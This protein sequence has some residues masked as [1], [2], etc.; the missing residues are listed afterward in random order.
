MSGSNTFVRSFQLIDLPL[1][2]R[3]KTRGISLDSE[4]YLARGLHTVE[5]AALS[6][7]PLADLGKP[8]LVAQVDQAQIIGQYRH[9]AGAPD[10][11][12]MFITPTLTPRSDKALETAWLY[13]LDALAKA[14]GSHGAQTLRAEVDENSRVFEVLRQ[15]GY[16][17]YAR[18][19]I[20]RRNPAT[21]PRT[22]PAVHLRQAAQADLPALRWHYGHRVPR[23]AQQADPALVAGGLLYQ[24][25][26]T[27][28]GY[29]L[30]S[31]GN[32]G[33]YLKRYLLPE[34]VTEIEAVLQTTLLHLPRA[35]KVPVYCCARQYHADLS[36]PLKRL[37][38]QP[39]VRQTVMVKYTTVRVAQVAFKEP[40]SAL[41]GYVAMPT[42]QEFAAR[43]QVMPGPSWRHHPAQC[44]YLR[45][46]D[47]EKHP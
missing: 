35:A 37:G 34:N 43:R 16:G 19:N 3:L 18:Q 20:W 2:H 38:F 44:G 14:A 9:R 45:T 46:I 17:A 40:A 29:V 33:I 10:A 6:Q 42:A 41:E 24:E 13:L 4:S 5:D 27:I 32:R 12:I 22:A 28:K 15:A 23:L 8:T 1:A 36:G 30:V 47:S 26:D 7:L 21:L 11:H 25:G 39:W 31:S